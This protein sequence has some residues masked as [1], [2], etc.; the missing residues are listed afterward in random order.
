MDH[1]P[2]TEVSA[3]LIALPAHEG[4]AEWGRRVA[5]KVRAETGSDLTPADIHRAALSEVRRVEDELHHVAGAAGFT[6]SDVQLVLAI[7][8]VQTAAHW[9]ADG[10]RDRF[11]KV[12]G[13]VEQRLPRLFATIPRTPYEVLADPEFSEQPGR[14]SEGVPWQEVDPVKSVC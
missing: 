1:V 11:Q 9:T 5:A 10:I 8:K 4:A 7:R 14:R 12:M 13:Q 6:G 3:S 2:G